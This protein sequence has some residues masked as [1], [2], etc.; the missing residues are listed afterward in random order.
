MT[1]PGNGSWPLGVAGGAVP[2]LA[3]ASAPTIAFTRRVRAFAPDRTLRYQFPATGLW[4]PQ[5]LYT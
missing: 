3:L 4:L 1:E 5:A 2:A